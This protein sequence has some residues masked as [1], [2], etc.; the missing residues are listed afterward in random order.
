MTNN[1]SKSF[2]SMKMPAIK[3]KK[4][5]DLVIDRLRTIRNDEDF[6]SFFEV[7]KKAADP[8]KEVGKPTLPRKQKKPNFSILQYVTG[9]E[10][11]EN[12]AYHPETAYE[13]FKPVYFQALGA[14][15][16]ANNDRFEQPVLKKFRNVEELLLKA[17]NKAD[18]SKELKVLEAGFNGDF[19]RNQL[20]SELHLIPAIVKQFAPVDF[21]E[22]CNTFQ[23]MDEEKRPMI[24]NIWTIIRIVLTSGVTSA[25][26]KRSFSMQRRIRTW[27]RSTMGQL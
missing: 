13:Y 5:A 15:I 1:L 19:D 12:N 2:Q 6:D 17:I 20:E 7:V 22:I 10:G 27:L 21:C 23:D 18:S 14:V 4:C 3:G 25:T 9:Y 26:P 8:I 11:P 16:S 24:R